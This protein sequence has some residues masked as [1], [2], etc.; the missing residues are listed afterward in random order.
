MTTAALRFI[1]IVSFK[2]HPL[3]SHSRVMSRCLQLPVNALIEQFGVFWLCKHASSERSSSCRLRA[4]PAYTRL[5]EKDM[6]HM[7]WE[8]PLEQVVLSLEWALA[9]LAKKRRCTSLT[10]AVSK[11]DQHLD[12]IGSAASNAFLNVNQDLVT[13]FVRL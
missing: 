12:H 2:G 10:F 9:S 11:A 7:F 8:S 4:V 6:A 5:V 13:R 1:D 3:Q